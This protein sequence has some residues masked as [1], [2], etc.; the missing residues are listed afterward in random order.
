MRDRAPT[1]YVSPRRA[2]GTDLHRAQEK[3]APTPAPPRRRKVAQSIWI[4]LE[5]SQATAQICETRFDKIHLGAGIPILRSGFETG[6]SAGR[7]SAT[8]P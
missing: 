5:I 3:T 8:V 4:G 6:S 2:Q 7:W 1:R